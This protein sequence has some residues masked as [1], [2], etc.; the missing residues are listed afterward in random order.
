M[1]FA[2]GNNNSTCTFTLETSL[3]TINSFSFESSKEIT[4]IAVNKY[5]YLAVITGIPV[6]T[7]NPIEV[8]VTSNQNLEYMNIR[9]SNSLIPTQRISYINNGT[10]FNYF[11]SFASSRTSV[12]FVSIATVSPATSVQITLTYQPIQTIQLKQNL[13]NHVSLNQWNYYNISV[14]VTQISNFVVSVISADHCA[15]AFGFFNQNSYPDNIVQNGVPNWESPNII[16]PEIFNFVFSLNSGY[17]S[18]NVIVHFGIMGTSSSCQYNATVSLC[19]VFFDIFFSILF[20]TNHLQFQ[21]YLMVSVSL[22][23]YQQMDFIMANIN[24]LNQFYLILLLV[25]ISVLLQQFIT[26]ILM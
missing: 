8:N 9:T 7:Y 16:I 21:V 13:S 19:K 17:I 2:K 25:Y 15:S 18:P 12:M 23:H 4:L 5:N 11:S 22:F 26:N 14:P 20:I 6:E 24:R 1:V 3:V 10:V